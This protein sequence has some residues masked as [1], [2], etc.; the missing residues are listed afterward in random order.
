MIRM[1]KAW[2]C[3]VP[4][5][6]VSLSDMDERALVAGRA[7]AWAPDEALKSPPVGATPEPDAPS[8]KSVDADGEPAGDHSAPSNAMA[9]RESAAAVGVPH[10]KRAIAKRITELGGEP[11]HPGSTIAVFIAKLAEITASKQDP[12]VSDPIDG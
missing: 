9:T 12:E 11:P 8:Q 5:E 6:L 4:G 1:N 3:Y 2:S 10:R 7:A